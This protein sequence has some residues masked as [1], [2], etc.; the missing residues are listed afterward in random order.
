MKQRRIGT[1]TVS[2][3]GLGAMPMSVREH[4]D[5][6]RALRTIARALDEGVTLI[7][8]ADAYSPDEATFGHNEVLI[9]KGL[10]EYGVGRDDVLV[11]TKGGHTR[12]GTDWLL[13]GIYSAGSSGSKD[14]TI[15]VLERYGHLD[16]VVGEN[17]RRDVFEPVVAWIVRHGGGAATPRP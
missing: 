13:D 15:N 5:E 12:R 17:A 14:V 6:E 4:N 3:I 10:R 1:R 7:D 16:V 9:A 8:T 2:A 11:A